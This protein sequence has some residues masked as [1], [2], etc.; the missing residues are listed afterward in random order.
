[1]NEL[2][3]IED[4][5]MNLCGGKAMDWLESLTKVLVTLSPTEQTSWIYDFR[6][7][8]FDDIK[9]NAWSNDKNFEDFKIVMQYLDELYNN[10]KVQHEC[11]SL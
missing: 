9:H 5:L 6:V 1:M 3:K 2:E 8:V 7:F 4:A 11:E 10:A